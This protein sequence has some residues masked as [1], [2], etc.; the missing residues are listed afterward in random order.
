MHSF[1]QVKTI[2]KFLME[3][4]IHRKAKNKEIGRLV[5]VRKVEE[6]KVMRRVS[7]FFSLRISIDLRSKFHTALLRTITKFLH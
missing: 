5:V 4:I 6:L 3:K 1:E 2:I 7:H